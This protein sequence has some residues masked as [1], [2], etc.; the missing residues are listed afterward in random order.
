MIVLRY[1]ALA[2]FDLCLLAFNQSGIVTNH[3]PNQLSGKMSDQIINILE[4]MKKDGCLNVNE[5]VLAKIKSRSQEI[6]RLMELKITKNSLKKVVCFTQANNN[7][8][9]F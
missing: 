4:A 7:K 6:F 9:L 2:D 5:Q 8:I 1:I 3:Y